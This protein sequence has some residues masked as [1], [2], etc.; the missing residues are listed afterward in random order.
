M[1]AA[2]S[3]HCDDFIQLNLIEFIV[4]VVGP[5]TADVGIAGGVSV[6]VMVTGTQ[7]GPS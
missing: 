4:D 3:L 6:G 2:E 7:C 1:G 5:P